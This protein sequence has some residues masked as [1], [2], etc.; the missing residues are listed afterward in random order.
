PNLYL[1]QREGVT[2]NYKFDIPNGAYDVILHFA[3]IKDTAPL[4]R[5]MDV[6]L[7]GALVLDDFDIFVLAPG[8]GVAM[9]RRFNGVNVADG[10]LNLDFAK[11]LSTYKRPCAIA[12]IEIGPAGVLP[13]AVAEEAPAIA[14]AIP[15]DYALDQN[16]PNP[17]NPSTNLTFNLPEPG[18]VKLIIYNA[19]G[20]F[21]R[22]VV[23]RYLD[24]GRHTVRFNASKLPTGTYFYELQVN[25]FHARRKM[26]LTR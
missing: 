13:K 16:Y 4:R 3:E 15:S 26:T 20:Q 12:A 21:V 6:T 14:V 2:M 9:Q 24:A 23:D 25:N 8:K 5:V 22:K 1:V 11:S 17:F 18:E 19:N 10:Q 7:E